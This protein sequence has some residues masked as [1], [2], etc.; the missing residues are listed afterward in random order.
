MDSFAYPCAS[1]LSAVNLDMLNAPSV[2]GS[3]Q[4]SSS[5]TKCRFQCLVCVDIFKF[6]SLR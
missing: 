6:C 4:T 2:N 1:D 5:G 3:V